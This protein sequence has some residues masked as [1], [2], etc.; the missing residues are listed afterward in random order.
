MLASDITFYISDFLQDKDALNFFTTNKYYNSI[1]KKEPLGYLVKKPVKDSDIELL[2]YR[3]HCFLVQNNNSQL[4]KQ[5][6]HLIF[7][8]SYNE[9]IDKFPEGV[10]SITLGRD[11]NQSL[12]E[13]PET[14][15][16]LF[17]GWKYNRPLPI[18]PKQLKQL[19][20][21]WEFN[22]PLPDL[23]KTLT[24]LTLGHNFTYPLNNLPKSLIILTIDINYNRY[25]DNGLFYINKIP[26]ELMFR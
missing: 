21:G 15:T 10:K 2:K 4:P 19:D 24:K 12:P 11:F 3:L 18:L 20:L 7:N 25:I 13:L 9:K 17:I 23:P 8:V 26:Y 6:S 14:L 22:Q 16:H 5:V 1:L